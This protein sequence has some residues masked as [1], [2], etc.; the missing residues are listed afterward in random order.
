MDDLNLDI[1]SYTIEDL[2]G[3]FTLN[4]FEKY[5]EEDIEKKELV[6]INKTATIANK[7]TKKKMLDFIKTAKEILIKEKCKP[8]KV[9][10][11][12]VMQKKKGGYRLFYGNI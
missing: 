2:E 11:D 5:R 4:T 7:E 3:L 8:E 6:L 1:R 12:K 9:T 10:S